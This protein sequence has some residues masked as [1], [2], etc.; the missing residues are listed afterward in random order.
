[1][2]LVANQP[3]IFPFIPYFRYACAGDLFDVGV[4]DP[5]TVK[6]H[7]RVKIGNDS[8]NHW[9]RIP[10]LGKAGKLVGKPFTEIEVD[11]DALEGVQQT[12][13]N[14]HRKSPYWRENGEFLMGTL[15][16]QINN[17]AV[18]LYATLKETVKYL[19]LPVTM[20]PGRKH[21]ASAINVTQ[22]IASQLEIHE[23]AEVYL[24]GP[25]SA[26][27]LDF[28]EY[29]AITGQRVEIFDKGH[30]DE[31][32]PYTTV[33]IASVLAELGKERTRE[34]ILKGIER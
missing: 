32:Y 14:M 12:L 7:H 23:E 25:K 16:L 24:A 11:V 26:E 1:M 9:L 10:L 5:F 20:V 34:L 15:G 30:L 18:Y 22:R 31:L 33:S 4:E 6:Y 3:R 21:S 28:N 2:Y 17:L 8:N 19:N 13:R 27:Y 29:Q